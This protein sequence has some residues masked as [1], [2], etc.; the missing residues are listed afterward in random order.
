MRAAAVLASM[1]IASW[2]QL[3]RNT[4]Q[5]LGAVSL[6]MAALG[7]ALYLLASR[8][9]PSSGIEQQRVSPSGRHRAIHARTSTGAVGYC[10]QFIVVTGPATPASPPSYNE[11]KDEAVLVADCA[12]PVE[13][14]W[15]DDSHL[16]VRIELRDGA[17]SQMLRLRRE[18]PAAAVQV[19][20]D[21]A[22]P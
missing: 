15:L 3:A 7:T 5:M 19:K 18:A 4:L 21:V 12:T 16:R 13:M 14:G 6:A 11:S 17:D 1:R 22:T 8:T 20:F 10:Y 9:L 2:R